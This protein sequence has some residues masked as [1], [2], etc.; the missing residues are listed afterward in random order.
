MGSP[1]P[2]HCHNAEKLKSI[3][4]QLRLFRACS[5]YRRRLYRTDP[6]PTEPPRVNI[7]VFAN[8]KFPSSQKIKFPSTFE[9]FGEFIVLGSVPGNLRGCRDAPPTKGQI[10]CISPRSRRCRER[11]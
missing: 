10:R 3:H 11:S 4:P 2:M 5:N 1:S 7:D 9:T 8:E 6:G